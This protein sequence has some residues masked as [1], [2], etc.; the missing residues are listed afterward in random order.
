MHVAAA[1][2]AVLWLITN[3]PRLAVGQLEPPAAGTCSQRSFSSRRGSARLRAI[4]KADVRHQQVSKRALIHDR[5][6]IFWL[7]SHH[8]GSA[9]R[10]RPS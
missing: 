4:A 8:A 10:A 2:T 9:R 7:R 1:G 5:A 3:E 6:G